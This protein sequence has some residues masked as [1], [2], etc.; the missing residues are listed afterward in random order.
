MLTIESAANGW[1][2]RAQDEGDPEPE[3]IEYQDSADR[4]SECEAM[5]RLLY[6][7]LERLGH[8]GSK[9]DWHRVCVIVEHHGEHQPVSEFSESPEDVA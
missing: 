6:T 5:Q 9:H 3:V 8:I 2:V 1:I 7:V 4:L